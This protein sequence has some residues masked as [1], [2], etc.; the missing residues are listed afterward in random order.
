MLA[1]DGRGCKSGESKAGSRIRTPRGRIRAPSPPAWL[2]WIFRVT[3]L[4]CRFW[5]ISSRWHLDIVYWKKG[6]WAIDGL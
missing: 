2:S 5:D 1:A 3:F 6:E 4:E